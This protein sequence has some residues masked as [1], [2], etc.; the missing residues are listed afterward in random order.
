MRAFTEKTNYEIIS[1]SIEFSEKQ[2]GR[3]PD[4]FRT[5]KEEMK[6][7]GK[8]IHYQDVPMLSF[9]IAKLVP[10]FGGITTLWYTYHSLVGILIHDP[11]RNLFLSY[12]FPS[13]GLLAG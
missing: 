1:G 3:I 8:V 4:E 2:D 6:K 10:F 13:A 9:L 11:F 7:P 12:W 5:V